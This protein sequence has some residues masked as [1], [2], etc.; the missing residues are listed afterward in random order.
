M[1]PIGMSIIFFIIIII[2]ISIIISNSDKLQTITVPT[3]QTPTQ[4]PAQT[5]T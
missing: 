3:A 2:I 1:S 5:S 4:T